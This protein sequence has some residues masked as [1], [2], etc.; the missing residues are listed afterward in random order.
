MK[1]NLILLILALYLVSASAENI[2]LKDEG[3]LLGILYHQT[4]AEYTALCYQAYNIAEDRLLAIDFSELEKPPA[5][6]VDVDE[7]VLGNTRYNIRELLGEATYPEDF[8]KWLEEEAS[9]PVAGAAEFLQ[10]ADSMGVKIFYITNR[11][12]HKQKATIGNLQKYGFPQANEKQVLCKTHKSSKEPRRQT[13]AENHEII[14]LIGD[15]LLDFSDF[16]RLD[17]IEERK[18]RTAEKQA[19]FGRRFIIL[20]NVMHG[21]WIKIINDFEYNL[22]NEELR[23]K[24]LQYIKD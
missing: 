18:E 14:M 11:R 24:R 13:A 7:T 3:A 22:S 10:L 6:V 16:F 23:A 2:K 12:D 1:K 20:P 8:Y 19:E 17:D 15:N 21:Y 4:A 9:E 5:L